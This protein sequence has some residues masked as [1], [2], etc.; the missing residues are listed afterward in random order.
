MSRKHVEIVGRI[1]EHFNRRD[2]AALKKLTA[3]DATFRFLDWGPFPRQTFEGWDAT[4]E[5]WEDIFAAV[6]D[7]HMEP[8]AVVAEGDYVVAT[9][10]TTG[11]GAST[12]V[13]VNMRFAVLVEIRD[14]KLVRLEVFETRAEALEAG[15]LR[16]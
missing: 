9:I 13:E 16:P 14:S 11:R 1:Y 4:R 12:G 8:E 5:Y 6:A 7:F 15:G 10:H 2:D 3:S